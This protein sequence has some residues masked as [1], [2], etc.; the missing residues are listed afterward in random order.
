MEIQA[1][2]IK[3]MFEK[4]IKPILLLYSYKRSKN[5]NQKGE[6]NYKEILTSALIIL[7]F[8]CI[9][10]WEPL[11]SGK[12]VL[13]VGNIYEQPFYQPYAPQG[14]TGS[15]NYLLYDQTNQLYPMQH[16]AMQSLGKGKLPLW[17]PHIMLGTPVLGTSQT[18]LLYPINLLATFLSPL[19]VILIRCIFNMWIAGF[20]MYLLI[21][22]FGAKSFGAYISSLAFMFSGFIVVWLGHPHS[23]SAIWLPVMILMAEL[24]ATL[25]YKRGFYA[26]ITGFII[27][28][29]F[30]G[31]HMETTFEITVAWFFYLMVRSFQVGGWQWLIKNLWLAIFSVVLGLAAAAVQIIPFLEWLVNSAALSGRSAEPFTPFYTNFWRNLLTLPA[32]IVPNLFSNPSQ[33]VLYQSYLPWTNFNEF[34]M[35]VGIIPLLMGILGLRKTNNIHIRI[36]S[37]GALLFLGLALR[38]PFI[39]YINQFPI[40]SLF[41][42]GRY[43]LIF[44]FSIAVAAGLT[45]DAWVGKSYNPVLWRRLSGLLLLLGGAILTVLLAISLILPMFEKS[46]LE[47]GR[48]L[49]TEQYA[50]IKVHSRSLD[51]VLL[52]VDRIY[53][54]SI[55]HFHFTNWKLYFPVLVSAFGGLWIIIWQRERISKSVF[56]FGIVFLVFMDL[57]VF[58]IGYN[59]SIKR[60]LVYPDTPAVQFLQKDT[61]LFRILPTSMQWR[62]NGPLVYGLSEIGGC[63]MPTKAFHEFRNIIAKSYTMPS[64]EYS[65][66]FIANSANSRLMDLL[67]VKYIVTTKKMDSVRKEIQLIWQERD[68]RIY[69]NYANMSRAFFVDRARYLTDEAIIKALSDPAFDPAAEVL[70]SSS[71]GKEIAI[72]SAMSSNHKIEVTKYEA[73]KVTISATTSKEGL[74]VLSDAY[75]PGWHAYIDGIEVPIYRANYIMRAISLPKGNHDI[76]FR[77][78]PLSVFLGLIIS[79]TTLIIM[80]IISVIS[81][82]KYKKSIL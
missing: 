31:G 71:L 9:F 16:Y 6:L 62:S 33:T 21:R 36:F 26:Y 11:V 3:K 44:D 19:S 35:Y 30:L 57:L 72:D 27:T 39:D 17:N 15:P 67:N 5:D 48:R 45:L 23:N 76:E 61:S 38:L 51:E 29:S 79:F 55:N 68:I 54:G 25:H 58:G 69:R 49:I 50:T 74:L 24:I 13:P 77:Y 63:E 40:F 14:Y 4:L 73:E 10:F 22:R 53:Q 56:K 82:R 12:T 80:G 60:D 78:E 37:W 70:L 65:T 81:F 41:P 75:Y 47:L 64:S 59:P 20:F 1:G 46:I 32:L 34:T 2:K 52:L 7:F 28:L 66:N 8:A 42:S 43:R 18:A